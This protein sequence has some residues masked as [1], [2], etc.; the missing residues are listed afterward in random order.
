M[1]IRQQRQ[2]LV[3]AIGIYLDV[4]GYLLFVFQWQQWVEC[5]YFAIGLGILSLAFYLRFFLFI[6]YAVLL[7]GFLVSDFGAPASVPTVIFGYY[8]IV[9]SSAHVK[10]ISVCDSTDQRPWNVAQLTTRH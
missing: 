3:E 8:I 9:L 5:M 1:G 7:D 2:H 6:S 10:H 4:H